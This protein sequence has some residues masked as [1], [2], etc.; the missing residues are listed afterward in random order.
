M[1]L[2]I[3]N[4]LTEWVFAYRD[5]VSITISSADRLLYEPR[6]RLAAQIWHEVGTVCGLGSQ[7]P[8]WQIVNERRATFASTPD[9]DA[10]RPSAR[11][12]WTNVVLAGDWTQTD[13]PATI[14]GAVRS[15]YRAASIIMEEH[16]TA[17]G[18]IAVR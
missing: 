8:P 2:G 12:G 9:Q 11:T 7:L 1:L 14:E 18:G 15:G 3:V 6:E 5:H 10:K 13:L 4:G 16:A 17:C